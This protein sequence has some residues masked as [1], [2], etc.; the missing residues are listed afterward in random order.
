VLRKQIAQFFIFLLVF[1]IFFSPSEAQEIKKAYTMP[2]AAPLYSPPPVQFRDNKIISVLFK[3]TPE[4]LQTLVPE[5]LVPNPGNLMFIYVGELNIENPAGGI[6]SYLEAGLG[7]PVAFSKTSGNYAVYLYL[8]KALPIVG[9]RE[10][11][12]WP[13]K[14]AQISFEVQDEKIK[15]KIERFGAPLITLTSTLLKKIDPVP[16]QPELPW[17]NLKIIPS[18]EQDSPPDVMQLTSSMNTGNDTKEL[19]NCKA[20]VEFGSSAMDPLGKI[21]IV[22]IVGAQFSVSDFVMNYGNVL[23]DYLAEGKK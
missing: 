2:S 9:G 7:V 14:D 22:E 17:F 15:A 12:G 5:P 18:V 19:Y 20:S 11:W 1:F 4:V 6:Y 21:E 23:H 13:K 16:R 10:I 3:T 8:D